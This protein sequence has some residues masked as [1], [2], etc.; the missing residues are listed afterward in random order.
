MPERRM[1]TDDY[2]GTE[3]SLLPQELV[4]GLVRE[5]AAAPAPGHQWMVGEIFATIRKH[6]DQHRVGRV[7]MA[8]ID[9][10]LDRD[11]HLVMQPDV[12][13]VTNERLHLV[14]DRIWGAPDL[15]VEVLS[16]FPRMGRLDERLAWF[17]QYGVRE[18]WLVH[19]FEREIEVLS[20][21]DGTAAER[22]RFMPRARIES[23]VLP[24]LGATMASMLVDR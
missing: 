13:V 1:T 22:R 21:A 19:Q 6:L 8:P 15:V 10:V 5:A 2:L 11:R 7:W 9:V 23:R 20:F 14:T 16:P 3:E 12:V 17:A 18:C 4:F 24:E